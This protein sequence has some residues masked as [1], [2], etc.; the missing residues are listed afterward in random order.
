[1]AKIRGKNTSPE[2]LLAKFLKELGLKP[3][4]HRRD[5]PGS[6]DLVLTRQKAII[7]I[8][9]CFWH[10][11][12]NCLRAALPTTNRSF[13]KKKISGNVKRDERQKRQ[14]R[15][16]GWKVVTFWTCREITLGSVVSKL[17]LVRLSKSLNDT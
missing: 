1:M 7:F 2:I 13:W 11:H 5:L 6:P 12:I 4:R 15:K 14:L 8:N 10:G 17:K 3:E 16:M 9:G